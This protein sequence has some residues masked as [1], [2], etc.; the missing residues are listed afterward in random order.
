MN[1]G[2]ERRRRVARRT[3]IAAVVITAVAMAGVAAPLLSSDAPSASAV[4]IHDADGASAIAVVTRIAELD[5]AIRF[6]QAVLPAAEANAAAAAA[7]EL[8]AQA[9]QHDV[10]ANGP[11]PP[12]GASTGAANAASSAILGDLA[13]EQATAAVLTA[14]QAVVNSAARRDQLRSSLAAPSAERGRL[15]AELE[16]NGQART[17]WSIQLLDRLGAPVTTENVRGLAAW[18][19]AESNDDRLHNPLATTMGALRLA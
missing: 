17:S 5:R 11:P 18:I 8:A 10:H 1:E 15:V 19:G 12:S 4:A 3:A 13:P 14:H 7:A 16:A 9:N 2:N 6:A